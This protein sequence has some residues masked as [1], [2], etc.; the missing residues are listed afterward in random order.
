MYAPNYSEDDYLRTM[1]RGWCGGGDETPCGSGSMLE[2]TVNVRARLPELAAEYGFKTVCDAGAGDLHWIQRVEWDVGYL[3]FD[4][5][6]RHP[7]VQR[8]DIR[9]QP[10]PPCDLILCRLVLNHI[11][12]EGVLDA[13]ALFRKSAKYL[14]A[15]S[16]ETKI[17]DPASPFESYNNWDLRAPP[18]D[19][20]E[21][22]QTINDIDRKDPGRLLCLWRIA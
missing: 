10:L 11:N 4:L 8:L 20:C 12:V 13:L 16:H 22:D 9:K 3:P 6:P 14:L 21:P 2:N 19:L 1:Q 15:T 7:S 5:V 17:K 18:F